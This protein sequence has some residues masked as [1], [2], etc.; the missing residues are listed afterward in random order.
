MQYSDDYPSIN[1]G[2]FSGVDDVEYFSEIA[3][4]FMMFTG[5]YILDS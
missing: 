5:V 2:I 3:D 4:I 1:K